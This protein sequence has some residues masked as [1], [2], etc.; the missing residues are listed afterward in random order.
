MKDL[1]QI[2]EEERM[3]SVKQQSILTGLSIFTIYHKLKRGE[4]YRPYRVAGKIV[5]KLSDVLAWRETT[6]QV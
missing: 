3:I 6:K 2:L 5:A 4:L 1:D